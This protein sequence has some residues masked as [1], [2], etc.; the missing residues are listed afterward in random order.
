MGL[1]YSNF[2]YIYINICENVFWYFV[3]IDKLLKVINIYYVLKV[4]NYIVLY[5]IVLGKYVIF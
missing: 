2:W 4:K 3:N 1:F 5:L